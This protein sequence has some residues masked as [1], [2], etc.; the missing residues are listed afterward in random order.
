[1]SSKFAIVIYWSEQDGHFLAGV[2]ELPSIIT[3]GSTRMEAL[4]NAE[5]MID[6]YLKAAREAS[7]PI[8]EPKGRMAFA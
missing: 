4:Q 5:E 1:M 3:D 2:P 7:W 6:A 8:P